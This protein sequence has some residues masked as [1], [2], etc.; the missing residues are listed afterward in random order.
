LDLT[1][2]GGGDLPPLQRVALQ[3]HIADLDRVISELQLHDAPDGEEADP[4]DA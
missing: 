2:T 3:T 4:A 1:P